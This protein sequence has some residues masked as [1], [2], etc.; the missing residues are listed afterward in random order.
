MTPCSYAN[1]RTLT[2]ST[3]VIVGCSVPPR[4]IPIPLPLPIPSAA[5]AACPPA[6]LLVLTKHVEGS[7][8][9]QQC[10]RGTRRTCASQTSRSTLRP[11][12]GARLESC[13]ATARVSFTCGSSTRPPVRNKPK[14]HRFRELVHLIS[15]NLIKSHLISSHLISIH[16]ILFHLI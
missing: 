10:W 11:K 5:G 2:G 4:W 7:S 3:R 12:R 8:A 15:S 13:R 6:P 14:R 1:A 9:P 16:L